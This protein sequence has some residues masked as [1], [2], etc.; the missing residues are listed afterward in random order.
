[1]SCWCNEVQASMNPRVM[2]V[3]QGTLDL[4]LFLQVGFKLG[5]NIFYNGFI[6]GKK[7]EDWVLCEVGHS[8]QSTIH[9][10][11]WAFR[12]S[13][14]FFCISDFNAPPPICPFS[15]EGLVAPCCTLLIP[16]RMTGGS[17]MAPGRDPGL[18]RTCKP[19]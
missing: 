15:M 7:L 5:I 16:F 11:S 4:Q 10:N 14:S 13:Q 1:M 8:S 6:A 12:K 9:P 18:L 17:N 2:V 3:E 19:Q